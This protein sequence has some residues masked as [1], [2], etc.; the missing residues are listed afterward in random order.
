MK[1]ILILSADTNVKPL[2]DA[3]ISLGYS[4]TFVY[5]T[6]VSNIDYNYPTEIIDFYSSAEEIV[7]SIEKLFGTI[8]GIVNCIEQYVKVVGEVSKILDLSINESKAYEILRDKRLMKEC[9]ENNLVCTPCYYGNYS[10][11]DSLKTNSF[12]YPLILK[13]SYGAASANVVKVENYSELEKVSKEIFRFNNTVLFKEQVGKTGLIVEEFVTGEEYS[14]DTIWMDSKPLVSGIMRKGNPLGPT[15]L[16]RI[17]Y[18]DLDIDSQVE[19]NILHETYRAARAA[20]VKNGATH[21]E[22]R[23]SNDKVYVIE[24]ALRPGGGGVF[25]QLFE[26]SSGINFFELF[27]LSSIPKRYRKY[28]EIEET[29]S[30]KKSFYFY[31][32]PYK[33]AG[34]IKKIYKNK[35]EGDTFTIDIVDSKKTENDYLPPEGK[36]IVYLGWILG[37]MKGGCDIQRMLDKL[38]RM[39]TIEYI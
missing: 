33:G 20:G 5:S 10:S 14:I 11:L 13:P 9:W 30:P 34:R 19:K 16:D 35:V 2:Y 22:V 28:Y 31:N 7:I 25:Y 18:I 29:Y 3:A 17:Y 6:D 36:S 4:P 15:F 1:K 39:F 21:V 12:K 37:E 27:I 32:I 8:V 38:D 26:K 24:G 23:V